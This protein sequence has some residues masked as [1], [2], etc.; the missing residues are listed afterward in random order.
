M[1]AFKMIVI[2]AVSGIFHSCNEML[3]FKM[4]VI[5]AVSFRLLKRTLEKISEIKSVR[6]GSMF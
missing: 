4:I 5:I 3:A 6:D 2:I 1:L